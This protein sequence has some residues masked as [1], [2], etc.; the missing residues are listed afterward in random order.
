MAVDVRTTRLRIVADDG[1]TILDLDPIQ[2]MWTEAQYLRFTDYSRRLIEFTDGSI[3]VLPM[4]TRKHQVILAFL[5]RS[6]YTFM[7]Q[8]GGIVL[9]AA[10]RMQIREG[11]FREPDLLLLL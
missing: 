9:F 1:D 2:G 6:L 8:Y 7:E 5:Y 10:L 3:E 4:P 11:K